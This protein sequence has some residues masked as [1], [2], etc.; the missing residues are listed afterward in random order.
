MAYDDFQKKQ[1]DILII[2]HFR[3]DPT[4]DEPLDFVKYLKQ[5]CPSFEKTFNNYTLEK[6]LEIDR[7][8]YMIA[9]LPE[10]DL[11]RYDIYRKKNAEKENIHDKN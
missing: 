8:N 2:G 6:S 9:K 1:P 10:E 7:I 3:I 11:I 4:K 5:N